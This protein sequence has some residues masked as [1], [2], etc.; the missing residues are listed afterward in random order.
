MNLRIKV[1]NSSLTV[2]FSLGSCDGKKKKR[3]PKGQTFHNTLTVKCLRLHSS[4]KGLLCAMVKNYISLQNEAKDTFLFKD[5]RSQMNRGQIHKYF[6][7]QHI[8]HIGRGK[9]IFWLD[10][11]FR[12]MMYF[13]QNVRIYVHLSSAQC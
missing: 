12:C 9:S 10:K 6:K 11:P 5:D 8:S 13:Y 7:G 4:S 1:Y 3:C 2:K